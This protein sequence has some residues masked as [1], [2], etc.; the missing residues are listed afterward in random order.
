MVQIEINQKELEKARELFANSPKIVDRAVTA[1]VNRTLT[2]IRKEVSVSIRKDYIISTGNIKKSLSI[3]RARGGNSSGAIKSIGSTMHLSN[4]KVKSYKRGP[5]KA[6]VK[7]GGLKPV[8]G[9]FKHPTKGLL[10]RVGT[11]SYPL[12]VPYGPSVP[13][14]FENEQVLGRVVKESQE[15]LDKRFLHEINYRFGGR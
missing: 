5:M 2:H 7:K 3:Q 10:R 11:S 13:Q 15:F 9:M 4:F 14:M 8:R 6:A 1:A 12:D